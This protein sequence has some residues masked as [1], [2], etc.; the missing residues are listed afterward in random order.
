MQVVQRGY[1]M[2]SAN[3]LFIHVNKKDLIV[4]SLVILVG[5]VHKYHVQLLSRNLD[6]AVVLVDLRPVMIIMQTVPPG[7]QTDFPINLLLVTLQQRPPRQLAL[8]NG[9]ILLIRNLKSP[10]ISGDDAVADCVKENSKLA[11][12]HSDAE[13]SFIYEFVRDAHYNT[14][15]KE[16]VI[17]MKY[18]AN[19]V[20][21]DGTPL[22]YTAWGPSE[23]AKDT[24]VKWACLETSVGATTDPGYLSKWRLRA[25][26][27][28]F[29][30]YVCKMAAN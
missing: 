30:S 13:N 19:G 10:G 18:E 20:W 2:D 7:L 25:S 23:P 1:Q 12:I 21:V 8:V 29:K 22:D 17:G 9:H 15:D 6:R 28:T 11:S 24:T 27:G 4:H 5:V 3:Q 14:N 26:T 16:T